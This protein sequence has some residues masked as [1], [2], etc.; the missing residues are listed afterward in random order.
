MTKR[1]LRSNVPLDQESTTPRTRTRSGRGN[2]SLSTQSSS[3]QQA[4]YTNPQSR[5]WKGKRKQPPDDSQS[6][7]SSKR[8][9]TGSGILTVGTSEP[10][11][12]NPASSNPATDTNP[13]SRSQKGKRKQPPDGSQ[14]PE[15]SKRAAIGS[16]VLAVSTSEPRSIDLTSSNPRPKCF[17]ISG[18]PSSWTEDNLFDALHDIDPSLT[19]QK[20]RPSLYP[21]CVSWV[22]LPGGFPTDRHAKQT[23]LLNLDASSE[24]LHSRTHLSVSESASRTAAVLKIDCDFYNLTP[25]NVPKGD[26]VAELVFACSTVKMLIFGLL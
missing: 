18:L 10:R 22:P 25:L 9:T 14:L 17:R 21:A 6:P 15:S 5:S 26:I 12:N 1:H 11:P 8:D 3:R 19:R 20:F 16:G 4:D 2:V 13:R 24:H 7:E 23:A